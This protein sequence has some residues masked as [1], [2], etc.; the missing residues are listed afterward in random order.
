MYDVIDF[1]PFAG[2]VHET[3]SLF[4]TVELTD[5]ETGACGTVVTKTDEDGLEV[6]EFPA[7][8]VA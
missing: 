5:G 7:V 4:A 2:S 6:S 1:P 8:L 3:S